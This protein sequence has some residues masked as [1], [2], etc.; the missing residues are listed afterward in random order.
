MKNWFYSLK[1]RSTL[2]LESLK[3][4]SGKTWNLHNLADSL[5]LDLKKVKRTEFQKIGDGAFTCEGSKKFVA[6]NIFY[7]LNYF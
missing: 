4:W 7:T 2:G 5:S 1:I 3:T 6:F